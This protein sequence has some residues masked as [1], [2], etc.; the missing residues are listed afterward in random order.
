MR[1]YLYSTSLLV[2]LLAAFEMAS[3]VVAPPGLVLGKKI[4]RRPVKVAYA[5]FS[6]L[7]GIGL[8]SKENE[9][10]VVGA[11]IDN[12]FEAW[13]YQAGISRA[14]LVYEALVEGGITR[15]LAVFTADQTVAKLGPI[16]S[17]RP[18]YI[19]WLREYGINTLY[20]HSG[21]SPAAL[22]YLKTGIVRDANEFYWGKYYWRSNDTPAPHNLFTSSSLWQALLTSRPA[23]SSLNFDAWK[24]ATGKNIQTTSSAEPVKGVA[25]PYA[26]EYSV[27]WNY[28]GASGTYQRLINGEA[29]TGDDGL[30]LSATTII[31]QFVSTTVL[32]EE[33]RR[34]FDTVG[35][36]QA[37]VL[38]G[39]KMI[40]G[41]WKKPAVSSRTKFYTNGGG[42]VIFP[43]G[44]IWVEVVSREMEMQVVN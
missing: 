42:E 3:F 41:T 4:V 23:P 11:M 24:F 39:G 32:D 40:R 15:Y 22:D 44:K 2:I 14:K 38:F 10:V 27:S 8:T 26:P 43:P 30:P 17:A 18:Y 16:R 12:N 33:G 20:L 9:G 35:S 28:V 5:N 13:E 1:K 25:L 6:K 36:G 29:R 19:D 21:G 31:V 34:E 37:R 7:N